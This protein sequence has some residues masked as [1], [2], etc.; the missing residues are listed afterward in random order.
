MPKADIEVESRSGN[1]RCG[2]IK[3]ARITTTSGSINIENAEEAELI[4]SSRNHYSK[5][6]IKSEQ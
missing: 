2:N 1:V 5:R 3:K 4:A 6:Y